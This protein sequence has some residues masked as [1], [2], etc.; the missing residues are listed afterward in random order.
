MLKDLDQYIGRKVTVDALDEIERTTARVLKELNVH[1]IEGTLK[2]EF[3]PNS[4]RVVI[5]FTAPAHCEMKFTIEEAPPIAAQL[6][7]EETP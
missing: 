3:D 1:L 6:D 2:A 5:S 4:N 7:S